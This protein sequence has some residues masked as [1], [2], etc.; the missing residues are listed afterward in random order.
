MAETRESRRYR[1]ILEGTGCRF[2]CVVQT[3]TQHK[4]EPAAR[5]L[6]DGSD[7]DQW[8]AD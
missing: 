4:T 2:G 7:F 6:Q 1:G 8:T 3:S 5:A